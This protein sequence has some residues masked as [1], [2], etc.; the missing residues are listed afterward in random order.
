MISHPFLCLLDVSLIVA[1]VFG[2]VALYDKMMI[3]AQYWLAIPL[4]GL[5]VLAG[6]LVSDLIQVASCDHS[7]GEEDEL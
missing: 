3:T 1:N 4:F 7:G 6:I 2:A 5:V